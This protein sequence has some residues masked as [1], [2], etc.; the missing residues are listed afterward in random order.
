M[1]KSV[2]PTPPGMFSKLT[3]RPKLDLLGKSLN[4]VCKCVN[5]DVGSWD[6]IVVMIPPWII[7]DN[8][9][10][11]ELWCDHAVAIDSCIATAISWLWLQG[12]KTVN[13]CCGH[14]T[15]QIE[16]WVIVA[17]GY[18]QNMI[19]MG[20]SIADSNSVVPYRTFTLKSFD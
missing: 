15:E 10:N 7:D 9:I 19:D 13:S 12:V 17:E 6:S 4:V 2:K 18:E 20:F 16:P 3:E 11:R 1:F 14:N 5:T 8:E